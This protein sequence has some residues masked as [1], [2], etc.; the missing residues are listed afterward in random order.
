MTTETG[1]PVTPSTTTITETDVDVETNTEADTTHATNFITVTETETE[2]EVAIE[3]KLIT[4]TKTRAD[5]WTPPECVPSYPM[6]AVSIIPQ[7]SVGGVSIFIITACLLTATNGQEPVQTAI[8]TVTKPAVTLTIFKITLK[9]PTVT[10]IAASEATET[11]T[12]H[13]TQTDNTLVTVTDDI[14]DFFTETGTEMIN[15]VTTETETEW[16]VQTAS[17]CS[18]IEVLRKPRSFSNPTVFFKKKF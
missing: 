11:Y 6:N 8:V 4:E 7:A 1:A 2:T 10:R 3:I 14:T 9:R 15:T 5:P 16:V 13:T 18:N 17:A 12:E